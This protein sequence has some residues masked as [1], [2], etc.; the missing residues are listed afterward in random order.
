MSAGETVLIVRAFS[1]FSH[2]ANIAEDQNQIRQRRA[3]SR[4]T[5]R[6]A[7][8]RMALAVGAAR[9]A[10]ISADELRSSSQTHWSGRC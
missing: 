2:L 8:A 10:G 9:K 4:P 3:S 1:Y 7:R 6:R 5:R